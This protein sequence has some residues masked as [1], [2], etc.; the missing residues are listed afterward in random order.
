MDNKKFAAALRHWQDCFETG[1]CQ[2]EYAD[3]I[4]YILADKAHDLEMDVL[5]QR[6]EDRKKCVER[7]ALSNKLISNAIKSG[8]I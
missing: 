2:D 8:R 5:R 1:T 7:H 3:E 6:I 4:A